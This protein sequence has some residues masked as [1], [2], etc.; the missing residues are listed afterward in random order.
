[1]YTSST[2]IERRVERRQERKQIQEHVHKYIRFCYNRSY[3]DN[4]GL[5]VLYTY[6][7]VHPDNTIEFI[8]DE[9]DEYV[10]KLRR[11]GSFVVD[12]RET[13]QRL[14]EH[15]EEFDWSKVLN[16]IGR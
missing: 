14:K 8:I 9:G 2:N 12:L 5:F 4:L 16:Y 15:R 3:I 7:N 10:E 13:V 1:M 11:K 6:I